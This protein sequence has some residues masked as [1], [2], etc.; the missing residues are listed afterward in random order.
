MN[1]PI[2]TWL[3]F[4][5]IV[6][7]VVGLVVKTGALGWFGGL[8]GDIEIKREG[9]RLYFPLASMIVISIVLSLLLS[10]LRRFF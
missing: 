10:V 1:A 9:F 3:I 5:G 4:A 2:G 8:P 6:L 7:V